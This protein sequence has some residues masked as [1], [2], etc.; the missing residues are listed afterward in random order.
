MVRPITEAES[1]VR[2]T[3]KSMNPAMK[4]GHERGSWRCFGSRARPGRIGRLRRPLRL[5]AFF[6][7]RLVEDFRV[8]SGIDLQR[9][10]LRRAGIFPVLLVLTNERNSKAAEGLPLLHGGFTLR[11]SARTQ[12][13]ICLFQNVSG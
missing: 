3:G 5:I 6:R 1:Y 13:A 2:E 11:W 9:R 8:H 7:C 10:V 4:N 12:G